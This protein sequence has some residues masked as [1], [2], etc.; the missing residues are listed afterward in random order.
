MTA[1]PSEID[2]EVR[3]AVQRFGLH[4]HHKLVS[5]GSWTGVRDAGDR[6]AVTGGAQWMV[7]LI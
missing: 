2:L 3:K 6:V 5:Q 7:S 4:A 1:A